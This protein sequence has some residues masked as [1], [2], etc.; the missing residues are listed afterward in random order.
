[1]VKQKKNLS[2]RSKMVKKNLKLEKMVSERERER[3][4]RR[5]REI[6]KVEREKK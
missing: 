5:E 2:K 3:E 1:M 4:R 6:R